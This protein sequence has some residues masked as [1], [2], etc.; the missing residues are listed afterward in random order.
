[1]DMI[2]E[3]VHPLV[4]PDYCCWQTVADLYNAAQGER[5]ANRSREAIRPL[6]V[7]AMLLNDLKWALAPRQRTFE[8]DRVQVAVRPSVLGMVVRPGP[9]DPLQGSDNPGRPRGRLSTYIARRIR[10]ER[11]KL[12]TV[13]ADDFDDPFV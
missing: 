5:I 12:A 6:A 8:G 1:M 10:K 7:R 4:Q 2:E 9:N 11:R 3:G 13:M